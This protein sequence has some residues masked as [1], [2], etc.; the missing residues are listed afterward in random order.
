MHGI[1]QLNQ[2][3]ELLKL[4]GCVCKLHGVLFTMYDSRMKLTRSI[5]QDV[6][7]NLSCTVYQTTIPRNIRMAEAPLY[8]KPGIIYDPSS[9]AAQAYLEFA[10]EF[11]KSFE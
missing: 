10:D 1:V 8:G 2:I 11:L 4:K 7:D 6:R 5:E 9:R 3:I